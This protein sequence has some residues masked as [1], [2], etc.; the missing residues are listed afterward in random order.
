MTWRCDRNQKHPWLFSPA[1]GVIA[2]AH[3]GLPE[4]E[5]IRVFEQPLL[6]DFLYSSIVLF[7]STTVDEYEAH[8][9]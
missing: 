9:N 6:E 3:L 1:K 4:N 7:G 2:C 5:P 8:M